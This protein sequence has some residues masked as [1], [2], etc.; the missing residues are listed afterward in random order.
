[1]KIRC[2]WLKHKERERLERKNPIKYETRNMDD[3]HVERHEAFQLVYVVE[4]Q[5]CGAVLGHGF[6]FEG[7]TIPAR[8]SA[9]IVARVELNAAA[10]E[11]EPEWPDV[12]GA[13]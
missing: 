13:E 4:C 9:E 11:A 7:M 6:G 8:S 1:M 2:R 3:G 5:R 10:F 12:V